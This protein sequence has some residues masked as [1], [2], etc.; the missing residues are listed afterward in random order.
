MAMKKLILVTILL[1]SLL[2]P[3][4]ITAGIDLNAPKAESKIINRRAQILEAYFRKYNSPLRE[5]SS[6]FIKAADRYNLDWRFVA[7]I[8]GV[9][10]TFGKFIPGGTDPKFSSFNG[11]GWGVYGTQAIY[12]NS[13]SDGIYTVSKGL[14]ENYLNKGLIEPYSIN[15]VY[16]ASPHWGKNISYFL[17]DLGQFEVDFERD[18]PLLDAEDIAVKVAGSSAQIDKI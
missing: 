6:D 1:I 10:S 2:F 7:A 18:N 12:F 9:E 17:N 14:R 15:R 5:Y 13:W 3:V 4:P 8:S 16:A 11:W